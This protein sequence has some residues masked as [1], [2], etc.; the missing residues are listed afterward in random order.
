MKKSTLLFIFATCLISPQTLPFLIV[1]RDQKIHLDGPKHLLNNWWNWVASI[2]HIC[3]VRAIWWL[4]NI[5]DIARI[6]EAKSPEMRWLGSSCGNGQHWFIIQNLYTHVRE[7]FSWTWT[8][9]KR[10]FLWDILIHD[11]SAAEKHG[12][13]GFWSATASNWEVCDDKYRR[14]SFLMAK[15]NF[16]GSIGFSGVIEPPS[17][18]C[19]KLTSRQRDV[20]VISPARLIFT[21]IFQR[22]LR[23][24]PVGVLTKL[25]MY[26]AMAFEQELGFNLPLLVLS[27]LNSKSSGLMRR[28]SFPLWRST[29]LSCIVRTWM[30]FGT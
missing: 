21:F 28:R 10:V 30:R 25:F 17:N 7:F 24:A 6:E 2:D 26:T 19:C 8:G 1:S 27:M 5:N 13:T 29:W 3:K 11:H 9:H 18:S 15:M 14:T 20:F 12:L 22:C 23:A 4:K 16:P